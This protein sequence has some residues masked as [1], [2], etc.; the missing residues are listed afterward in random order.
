[1]SKN[2]VRLGMVVKKIDEIISFEQSKWLEKNINFNTQKRY[3][4]K[5]NFEKDFY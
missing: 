5:N 1:M 4:A 2:D 3:R